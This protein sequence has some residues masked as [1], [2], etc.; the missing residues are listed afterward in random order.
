M[1][2]EPPHAC[3]A[4]PRQS[5][6]ATTDTLFRTIGLSQG[7]ARLHP[8]AGRSRDLQFPPDDDSFTGAEKM[9]SREK[10]RRKRE[11]R[12][13][14]RAFRAG[15]AWETSRAQFY[16]KT[17][18]LALSGAAYRSSL[19]LRRARAG[20]DGV[21]RLGRELN[22]WARGIC[23]RRTPIAQEMIACRWGDWRSRDAH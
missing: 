15:A 23:N 2:R 9:Q 4:G 16:H 12:L 5:V 7:G 3:A 17:R 11:F 10:W 22:F 13:G 19:R 8:C 14:Q 6:R 1:Q 18:R 21:G 20:T